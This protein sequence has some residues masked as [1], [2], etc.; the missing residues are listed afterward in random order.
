MAITYPLTPPDPFYLSRLSL[1]GVSAVSRNTSPFTLQTQQY[2][3]AGQ[4]WLGSVDCPPMTRADA[5]TMLAFLL[6][7]QRGTLVACLST[8]TLPAISDGEHDWRAIDGQSYNVNVRLAPEH[9]E[10]L[11]DLQNLPFQV[12]TAADGSARVVR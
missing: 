5:E 3:H 11:S 12:G 10:R 4:A 2:N 6:S 9:R 1:T 8:A 7:A